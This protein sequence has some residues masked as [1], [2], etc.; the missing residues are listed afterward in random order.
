MSKFSETRNDLF[1]KFIDYRTACNLWNTG[2]EMNLTYFDRFCTEHFPGQRNHARHDRWLVYAE[3]YR[4]Q[5]ITDRKDSL[6]AEAD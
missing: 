2:Y 3:G 5:N 6:G 4:K 1:M